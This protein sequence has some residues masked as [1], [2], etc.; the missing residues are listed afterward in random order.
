MSEPLK[1][2][3]TIGS[4]T[5]VSVLDTGD[6]E[7]VCSCGAAVMRKM[8]VLREAKSRLTDSACKACTRRRRKLRSSALFGKRPK[9]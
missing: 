6:V 4:L 2:G 5:V 3:D 8:A 9:K 1:P 7:T